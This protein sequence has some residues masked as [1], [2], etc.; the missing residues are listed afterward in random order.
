MAR[1]RYRDLAMIN[2]RPRGHFGYES[3]PP[4]LTDHPH[5]GL[6]TATIA[7]TGCRE[8]IDGWTVV[9][10][11]DRPNWEGVTG[12]IDAV[13]VVRASSWARLGRWTWVSEAGRS[14]WAQ[15]RRAISHRQHLPSSIVARTPICRFGGGV[16][17]R[18]RRERAARHLLFPSDARRERTEERGAALRCFMQ[19]RARELRDPNA[20]AASSTNSC[21][22][23]SHSQHS[24]S[25]PYRPP[26][27]WQSSCRIAFSTPAGRWTPRSYHRRCLIHCSYSLAHWLRA[28]TGDRGQHIIIVGKQ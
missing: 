10:F 8:E 15:T 20:A 24:P 28:S 27:V 5:A 14:Q 2:G 1:G 9:A 26:F 19:G 21:H 13:C 6:A 4:G 23:T 12:R 7:C 22:F 3:S 16:L 18:R 11:R 25:L 17:I